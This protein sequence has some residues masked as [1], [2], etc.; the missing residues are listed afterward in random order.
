MW[1]LTRAVFPLDEC[2]YGQD[3]DGRRFI[4]AASDYTK[5]QRALVEPIKA[6]FGDAG[7]DGLRLRF[8]T[9]AE[10]QSRLQSAGFRDFIEV[11][12]LAIT[13]HGDDAS[14]RAPDPSGRAATLKRVSGVWKLAFD[15]DGFAADRGWSRDKLRLTTA[16]YAKTARDLE[17][18]GKDIAVGK[19]KTVDEAVAAGQN[20]E[21]QVYPN[22]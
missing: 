4:Q 10:A 7:L 9:Q 12:A 16:A 18:L 22:W 5:A 11:D 13:V 20:I 21:R 1:A 19:F 2:A 17:T 15:T 3:D 6:R 8:P 14:A